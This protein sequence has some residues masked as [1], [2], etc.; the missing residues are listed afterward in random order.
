MR[1]AEGVCWAS[2]R[3]LHQPVIREQPVRVRLTVTHVSYRFGMTLKRWSDTPPSVHRGELCKID[4]RVFTCRAAGWRW[5][6]S[7]Q[8][9]ECYYNP[10]F[11]FFSF[12]PAS[13]D[14]WRCTSTERPPRDS[15]VKWRRPASAW[16]YM[17][18][19]RGTDASFR[20]RDGWSCAP[21]GCDRASVK[22]S[23]RPAPPSVGTYCPL[24]CL[25]TMDLLSF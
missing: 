19:E 16:R 15:A 8:K 10:I 20:S 6:P 18:P 11:F 1:L 23:T 4:R 24:P 21:I 9:A 5:R 22:L 7:V 14:C 25:K 13:H 2:Y 12:P 3:E 17:N